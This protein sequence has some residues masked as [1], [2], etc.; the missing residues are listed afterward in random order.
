MGSATWFRYVNLAM[1]TLMTLSPL[2]CSSATASG[3]PLVRE[4]VDG[5]TIVVRIAGIDET[6]RLLGV[7]TPETSDPS[8]PVQC[9][10]AE[11]TQFVQAILPAGTPVYLERDVEARDRYGRLLAYV[12]VDADRTFVN[13]TIIEEGFGD[14]SIYEPNSAYRA[15]LVAARTAAVT[16]QRGLWGACGGPDV[17]IDPP[18]PRG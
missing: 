3:P 15:T 12:F 7:D 4:V 1:F 14:L 8:R 16:Q 6:V 13:A 2:G 9:F 10:G 17:A 11:A 5:D 18:L